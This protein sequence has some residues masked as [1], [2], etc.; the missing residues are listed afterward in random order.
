MELGNELV[1]THGHNPSPIKWKLLGEVCDGNSTLPIILFTEWVNRNP[2]AREVLAS[3][4][5]EWPVVRDK[6]KS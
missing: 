4:G 1:L 3:M 6:V 2:A 5:I